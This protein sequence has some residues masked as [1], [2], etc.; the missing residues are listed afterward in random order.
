MRIVSVMT[1]QGIGDVHI[2]LV[3]FSGIF[4]VLGFIQ[5]IDL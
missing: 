5:A 2:D 4:G 1:D 3:A